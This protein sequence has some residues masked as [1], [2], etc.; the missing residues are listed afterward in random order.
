MVAKLFSLFLSKK[1]M[2]RLGDNS[3]NKKKINNKQQTDI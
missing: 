2:L 1:K 3:K